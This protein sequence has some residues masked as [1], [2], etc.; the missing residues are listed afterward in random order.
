M[1]KNVALET[2]HTNVLVRKQY[3]PIRVTRNEKNKFK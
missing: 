2:N 1:N 3:L